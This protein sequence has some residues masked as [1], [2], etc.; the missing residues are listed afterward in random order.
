MAGLPIIGV[1]LLTGVVALNGCEERPA[2]PKVPAGTTETSAADAS[3]PAQRPRAAQ[4]ALA[5]RDL[6]L[7]ALRKKL[8]CPRGNP[9]PCRVVED[10]AKAGRWVWEKQ[11]GTGRWA[12][13]TYTIADGKLTTDFMVLWAQTVPTADVGEDMLPLKVGSQALPDRLA[14]HREKLVVSLQ[15]DDAVSRHNR[16]L[17]WVKEFVP[18]V[19]VGAMQTDGASTVLISENRTYIRT[20]GRKTLVIIP[21][22]DLADKE[23]TGT[24]AELWPA[25]W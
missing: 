12:G 1:A 11:S 14:T 16:A 10:F 15:G 6:D 18:T 2:S 8:K 7:D 20:T 23:G 9:L 13:R 4:P 5:P 21:S 25:T 22:S 19:K 3:A 17:P 24:Y